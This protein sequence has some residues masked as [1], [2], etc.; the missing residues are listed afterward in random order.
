ML[1][2]KV[3]TARV[4]FGSAGAIVKMFP[5]WLKYGFV[6]RAAENEDRYAILPHDI[7]EVAWYDPILKEPFSV[8]ATDAKDTD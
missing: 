2:D 5:L 4:E 3:K 7:L 8:E 6:E 1:H